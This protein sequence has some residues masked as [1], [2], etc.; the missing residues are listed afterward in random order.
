MK[1]QGGL[2]SKVIVWMSRH[3]PLLSQ[4]LELEHLFPG[5]QL[6][7]DT[8]AFSSAAMIKK[9]FQDARGDE[10]VV[11]APWA[12]IRELIRL[13]I[14]PIYAEMLQITATRARAM[15][16]REVATMTTGKSSKRRYYKF[17]KFSY[18]TD[19][20]LTLVPI[21]SSNAPTAGN[22]QTVLLNPD[23]ST[24]AIINQKG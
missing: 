15:D 5:H 19:V 18:C 10:M 16:P 2:M 1:L 8:R 20:S 14:K 12:V 4:K 21:P 6:V 7:L 24:K 17:L 23:G 22:K 13:G 3:A 11:V 9:R